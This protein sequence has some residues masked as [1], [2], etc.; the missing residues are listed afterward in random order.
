MNYENAI[1]D[2]YYINGIEQLSIYIPESMNVLLL[3][4]QVNEYL[5]LEEQLMFH[6]FVHA[7]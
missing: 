4:D 3:L 2:D 6:E 7:D 5:L 1:Q